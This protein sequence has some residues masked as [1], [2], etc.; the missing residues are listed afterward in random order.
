M[1]SMKKVTVIPGDGIGPE[2]VDSALKIIEAAGADL[3]FEKVD[4]GETVMEKEGTH[5]PDSVLEAG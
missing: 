2:V 5:L 1:K 3:E 4:A